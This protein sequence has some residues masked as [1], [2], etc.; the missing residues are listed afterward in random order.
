MMEGI[1]EGREEEGMRAVTQQDR[2]AGA[3]CGG[4]G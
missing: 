1:Q 2:Q 3:Y 4:E